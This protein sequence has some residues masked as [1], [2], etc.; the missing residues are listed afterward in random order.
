M[1]CKGFAVAGG[2]DMILDPRA[3]CRG[4]SA[5]WIPPWQY[6]LCW[7]MHEGVQMVDVKDDV[8]MEVR[9]CQCY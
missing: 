2:E 5:R 1:L 8:I 3:L 6:P 4:G 9:V 7:P